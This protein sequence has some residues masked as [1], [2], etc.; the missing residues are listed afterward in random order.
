MHTRIHAY[1]HHPN[2][3]LYAAIIAACWI[4]EKDRLV[5]RIATNSEMASN[6]DNSHLDQLEAN[7]NRMAEQ[8][9][10]LAN[11]I[12]AGQNRGTWANG[13]R[14]GEPN[15]QTAEEIPILDDHMA[16]YAIGSQVEL[17]KLK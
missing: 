14:Q 8:L 4:R 3:L 10:A 9:Q 1:T 5:K 12:V 17:Q 16:E 11:A 2:Y 15:S 13:T 7:V 6:S